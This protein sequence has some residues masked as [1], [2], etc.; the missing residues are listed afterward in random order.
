MMS[1]SESLSLHMVFWRGIISSLRPLI[2]CPNSS[3]TAP[4]FVAALIALTPPLIQPPP[5]PPSPPQVHCVFADVCFRLGLDVGLAVGQDVTAWEDERAALVHAGDDGDGIA[6]TSAVDILVATPGRLI[7]HLR[8]GA[9]FSLKHLRFLV[10]DEADRLLAGGYQ[11]S[12]SL[13]PFS[14]YLSLP[15]FRT[16]DSDSCVFNDTSSHGCLTC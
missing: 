5:P 15:C 13:S 14:P 3:L 8:A 11:A 6:P 1:H 10:I 4:S 2:T 9:G 16:H 12:I 7:E